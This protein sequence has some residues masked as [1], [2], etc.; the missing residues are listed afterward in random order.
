MAR[1]ISVDEKT[2]GELINITA[3]LMQKAGEQI[4][5]SNTTRLS[6][7]LLKSCLINY[8]RLEDEILNQISFEETNKKFTSI[9]EITYEWFDKDFLDAVIG[10]KHV[11]YSDDAGDPIS[12]LRKKGITR[13]FGRLRGE[14]Y[15]AEL[16]ED[17][18]IKTLHDR[19]EYDS[20]STAASAI[21]GYQ[22]NGWRWWRYRKEDSYR[23]IEEMR[24]GK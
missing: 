17:S 21:C 11:S 24:E 19:K 6:V 15:E 7:A 13:I 23:P 5:L 10:V 3:Q 8:P 9:E 12:E 4:S 22:V 18:K 16:T 14:K 2:Y 1:T 20:L